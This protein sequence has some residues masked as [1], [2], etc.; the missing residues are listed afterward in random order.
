MTFN[1]S[2]PDHCDDLA[3]IW[4]DALGPQMAIRPRFVGYSAQPAAGAQSAGQWQ[5]E[6]GVRVGAV[7]VSAKGGEGWI[8][9]LVVR[10]Q[11]QRRGHGGALLAWAEDWLRAAGASVIHVGA[12]LRP[13]VPGVPVESTSL[14][15]F[16]KR[17]YTAGPHIWDVAR[18]LA[19]WTP[20]PVPTGLHV[21]PA[22]STDLP[23]L[24]AF[25][26][27]EFPGRWHF[28]FQEFKRERGWAHDY[29]LTWR[30][31]QVVGFCRLTL[32][33]DSERPIDRY[34]LHGLPQ[35]WGQ[36]GPIG[37]AGGLRGG[38]FGRATLEGGLSELHRRGVNGAVIDWTDLIGFYGKFG[39]KPWREYIRV[40]RP[41]P[42]VPDV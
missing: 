13:F 27:R 33:P 25:L 24:D 2:D 18:S 34:Y 14:D 9:A 20:P 23:A 30:G 19:T 3:D 35:P 29:V 15:F 7:L 37:V 39:F 36:L 42:Q 21:A 28:E 11:A 41:L 22:S 10:R 1:R 31:G 16:V 26:A 12:G 5:H 40:E 8:D 38:G 32:E 17:S 6:D 4:N